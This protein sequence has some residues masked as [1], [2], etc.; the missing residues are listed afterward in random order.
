MSVGWF[1]VVLTISTATALLLLLWWSLARQRGAARV[2][3]IKDCLEIP[4]A[5]A[6]HFPQIRR[7]LDKDDLVYLRERGSSK[8]SRKISR[9]R[10]R[11]VLMYLDELRKDL[12][13][14]LRLAKTIAVLSP[15]VAPTQEW[16]RLRLTVWFSLQYEITRMR[17]LMGIV[18]VPQLS[19]VTD[20]VSGLALR[21]ERA[22]TEL[23][24]RAALGGGAAS[25]LN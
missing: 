3:P 16:E 18:S 1:D 13:Q 22:M 7:A 20:M 15:K 11:V 4:K 8:M 2:V 6:V 12:N 21:L 19:S 5:H 14:L 9:E 17:L 24:E 10:A 25:P 23:G